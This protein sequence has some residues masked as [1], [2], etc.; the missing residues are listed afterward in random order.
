MRWALFQYGG[1]LQKE[2]RI[3]TYAE[4]KEHVETPEDVATYGLRKQGES[5]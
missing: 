4:R 1:C 5:P 2:I 3:Y